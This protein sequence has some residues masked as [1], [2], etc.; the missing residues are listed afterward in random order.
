MR[1]HATS[2]SRHGGYAVWVIFIVLIGTAIGAWRYSLYREESKRSP[3]TLANEAAASQRRETERKALEKRVVESKVQ[4]DSLAG[5]AKSIDDL[6]VRWDDA[7]KI[8]KSSSRITLSGPVAALQSI[9]R[10]VEQLT[11]PPCMD[12][13]RKTLVESMNRTIQGF[14]VFMGNDGA[15]ASGVLASGAEFIAAEDHM[16]AFKESREACPK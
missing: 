14:M 6:L 12:S 16:T 3:Q 10:E 4:Q 8:A 13:P 15:K 2:K 11:L 5:A 7:V 9:R 1:V